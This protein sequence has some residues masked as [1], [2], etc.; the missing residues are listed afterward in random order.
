MIGF[1]ATAHALED[2][3]WSRVTDRYVRD[4]KMFE[5]LV[6]N[7]CYAAEEILKRLI[8]AHGRGYWDADEEE[9]MLL[10]DRFL[11]LEGKIELLND[12]K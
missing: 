3:V 8:E 4:E 6:E 12:N 9:K 5:R 2:W 11:E 1:A 7:N 10:R